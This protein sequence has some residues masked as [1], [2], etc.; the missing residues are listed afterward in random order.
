MGNKP[1][2]ITVFNVVC[3]PVLDLGLEQLGLCLNP[4][5]NG[6]P[7]MELTLRALTLL[8]LLPSIPPDCVIQPSHPLPPPF[9]SCPQSFPAAESF[10]MS[11][12]FTS[13]GQSIGASASV[14]PVNIQD[15]FPLGL[16]SLISL[17]S[18]VFS[19]T[20][21]RNHQFF[22][23]QPALSS[24]IL[25]LRTPWTAGLVTTIITVL[26]PFIYR[27]F[28][29]SQQLRLDV[30]SLT[31]LHLRLCLCYV[32]PV[33]SYGTLCW[34]LLLHIIFVELSADYSSEQ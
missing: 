23:T 7:Y 22:S 25:V 2:N 31:Q 9:S 34:L 11:Q 26:N 14:L 16:T 32:L 8:G 3:W 33:S 19:S 27:P 30:A 21:I 5:C 18:C 4:A 6:H 10:P 15:W 13:G 24:S 12:L 1:I 28:L 20:T 29:S 17:L